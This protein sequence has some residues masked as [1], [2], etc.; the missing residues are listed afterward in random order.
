MKVTSVKR[1][2]NNAPVQTIDT[3][4]GDGY[5]Q[6][7][8]GSLPDV[9][10]DYQS[11]RRQDVK[12]YI[13]ERYNHDGKQRVFSAGTL[14]TLKV[15]AVIK[16]VARTMKIP[17]NIVNY[18]TA[19]FD[20][21]KCDF[22]GIFKLAATEKKIAKFIND[23][24]Q[25]FESIRT[26]MFQP[27]SGSVHASALLVTPDYMDGEDVE[28]FDFV[29]IKKVDGLLVSENDGYELDELGLLKNDCLATKELSKLHE[30]F[31]LVKEHYH[32][33]VSLE[34]IVTG[35]M[36]DPR[37]YDILG[38][39]FTQNVFQFG[40]RGI[41]KFLIDLK[42]TCIEHLIAA[43]AIYRPATMGN[44]DEFVDCKNGLIA[45]VY[46]WGTYNSLK[47]TYGVV[48]Y[49]EQIV[50]LAREIGGFSLGDGVKLVK[51][52]SKKKTEK[53]QAMRDKFMAGADKNGCPAEDRDKIWAQI[54]A[55]GTYCF[56]KSHATAYAATAYA[57]AYLKVAYP[58]AF[59]TVALQWADDKEIVSLMGEMDACSQAHVVAPD[60]NV[61]G[62]IFYTDYETNSIFWSLSR[63][64]ML[65][66]KAV[67]WIINERNKN[68]EFTSI[69][70]FIDR[71]FKYKLKKYEYWD[72]PD[73]EEEATR[74]PVNA[75]HIRNLIFA[76]C[77]DKI[78][79]AES[80]VERFAILEKA[81]ARLGFEI[82]EKD[83]PSEMRGKHYWWSQQQ[84]AVSGMGAIDYKRIYDNSEA[85][86]LIKGKATYVTL[87]DIVPSEMEDKKVAIC[88]TVVDVEEKKYEDKRTGDKK[89]FCKL[90]LQQ[91]ND[92]CECIV[93]SEEYNELR[94]QLLA[95]KDKLIV[96][97]AAV[98][99][100]DY[101]GKNNLQF[102]RKSVLEVL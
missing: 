99:Y 67:D 71:I 13:E 19:I 48:V 79:R 53:I 14:T 102:Y 60:I 72:D 35:P 91:N 20:D 77:F 37:V 101:Q 27:R 25:L 69:E 84:I 29:P 43:N 66:T 61:S 70:N 36:D 80:V 11:D 87:G 21:D 1:V 68:G 55:A 47:N 2:H 94:P 45:P 32:E 86:T 26:L 75:R 24:P 93:W 92:S 89:V 54:E 30:V 22:T 52:V 85:K 90:L 97:S 38:R 10:Q 41:T 98:K 59:Y 3:F 63:I 62:Q 50:S 82:T 39:G 73:N 34:S 74:C 31:D 49:Q 33:D 8:G 18:I 44:I 15:K 5:L 23:Y 76:G 65:G 88:A 51:F 58:T 7:P 78:E 42:P 17:V 9:D 95:A 46:L 28:C 83:V 64:K 96:C 4:V 12:A 100:S 16:D 6:G 56:N 57:G 81:A 40:S